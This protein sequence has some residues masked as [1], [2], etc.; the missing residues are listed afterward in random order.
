MTTPRDDLAA[1]ALGALDVDEAAALDRA[2]DGDPALL[3]EYSALV[4]ASA[5]LA[6]ASHHASPSAAASLTAVRSRLFDDAGPARAP[7]LFERFGERF[8][9]IFDVSMARARELI[10]LVDDPLAWEP[11]PGPGSWLIHFEGGPACAGA[12]NGFV[13]LAP[14]VRFPW[15]R[16]DGHEHNL[17]LAG[18]GEDSLFGRAMPGD[19][20][21]ADGAT[22]HDFTALGDEPYL[23]AVRVFGVDFDI[24]KP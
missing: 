8:A 24:Q 11:G 3:D 22:E 23:F 12:D 6:D 1:H 18:I 4:E 17:I 15:H 16:H 10:G 9:A 5:R 20:P 13:K 14:G 19:E 21:C 2:L 7:G